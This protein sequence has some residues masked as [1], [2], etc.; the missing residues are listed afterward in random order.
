MRDRY[1]DLFYDDDYLRWLLKEWAEEPEEED[2]RKLKEN[3]INNFLGIERVILFLSY[4]RM[5]KHTMMWKMVN[6]S[7]SNGMW[8]RNEEK[9]HECK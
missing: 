5:A 3:T 7:Q 9:V 1:K 8:M 4:F 2:E 6:K